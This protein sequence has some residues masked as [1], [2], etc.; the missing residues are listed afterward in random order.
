MQCNRC[1][2]ILPA[3]AAH[4]PNCSNPVSYNAATQ[5]A[6]PPAPLP[7]PPLAPTQMASGPQPPLAPTQMASGSQPPLAPTQM[8]SGAAFQAPPPPPMPGVPGAMGQSGP[9]WEFQPVQPGS[10]GP[11]WP[12]VTPG[13]PV[14]ATP[15]IP[16]F[17]PPQ[18]QRRAASSIVTIVIL[19]VLL[20]LICSGASIGGGIWYVQ[21]HNASATVTAMNDDANATATAID[22]NATATV[23][24]AQL[25]PTPY[26]PYTES[27]PP[28]RQEFSG[29]AQEII[30]TAQMAS[31][32]NSKYQ[33]T[34]LES[35]FPPGQTM[36]LAYHWVNVG[37]AGYI[38]TIWY[39][40]GQQI[41]Q[42]RSDYISTNYAYYNG[43]VSYSI[44]EDGQ[45]AVEVYWCSQSDCNNRQLAWV[46]P[47][48]ISG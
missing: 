31:Q 29:A 6:S 38:Y 47:F 48:T 45:G 2:Y 7:P 39:F 30:P 15:P 17:V 23:D 13:Q 43:Y 28:S 14:P 26:P 22:D 3:G 32:L 24:T 16:V 27:S 36:Y 11:G 42:G 25:T 8:A 5:L 18:S 40:N 34:E 10:S 35:V 46:R 9:G 44:N 4:C 37:N 20:I 19:V 21:Q 41:T 33:P 1:G 12:P